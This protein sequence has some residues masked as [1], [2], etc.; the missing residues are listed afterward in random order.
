MQRRAATTLAASETADLDVLIREKGSPDHRRRLSRTIQRTG[1]LERSLLRFTEPPSHRGLAALTVEHPGEHDDQWLYLPEG[2]RVK[3]VPRAQSTADFAGTSFCFEDLRAENLDSHQYRLLG[4]VQLQRRPA[5]RVE[6]LPRPDRPRAI[7]GY[8][9]RVISV[10]A[11]RWVELKI[12]FYDAAG[13]LVKT[14]ENTDWRPVGPIFR[15]YRVVMREEQRPRRTYIQFRSWEANVPL[16]EGLFTL[17]EL[18]RE[19]R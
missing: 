11:E 15:P 1:G 10:D 13:R 9:R 5:Y 4:L 17:R 2:R 8:A 12:E 16:R 6:A 3:R 19:D 14:Q 7:R 18:Q